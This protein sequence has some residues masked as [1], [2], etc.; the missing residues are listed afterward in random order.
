MAIRLLLVLAAIFA[1]TGCEYMRM[2][3]AKDNAP[4]QIQPKVPQLP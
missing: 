4:Q 1:S 2:Q 3:P